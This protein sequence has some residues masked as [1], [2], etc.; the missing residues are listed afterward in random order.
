MDS[1]T[2]LRA[3][4]HV[5]LANL[6]GRVFQR[7]GKTLESRPKYESLEIA[8]SGLAARLHGIEQRMR[9]LETQIERQQEAFHGGMTIERA[10]ARSPRAREVLKRHHLPD[11]SGCTV[12]FDETLDEATQAYGLDLDHLLVDLNALIG[13]PM[14]HPAASPTPAA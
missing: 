12:R 14:G 7:L 11:C 10:L 2:S 4:L 5:W 9:S 3:H 1:P 13:G 8:Q 6:T